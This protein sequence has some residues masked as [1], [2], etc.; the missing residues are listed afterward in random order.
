M[1]SN[2][3]P[4][5]PKP[6]RVELRVARLVKAHGLK[7]GLKLEVYTDDPQLRFQPGNE[8]IL[9]VPQDSPWFGKSIQL[10]AIRE[11]N[12]SPVAFFEGVD[13]RSQAE[14][15]VKAILWVEHDP[16][17][18]PTEKDAWFD[19]ELVG[20]RVMRDGVELGTVIRVDHMPA[21][22]LLVIHSAGTEVLLPF[23]SAFVPVVNIEGG[24]L[25]ITPPGGLFEA[26]SEDS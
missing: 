9:Q 25:E 24:V 10:S 13:D 12:S 7:G 6:D 22:D 14:T 26:I 15:L 18:R 19:H 4:T 16:S 20:L 11:V 1:P 5:A 2:P 21:Q 8:F 3:K 23:V 17:T